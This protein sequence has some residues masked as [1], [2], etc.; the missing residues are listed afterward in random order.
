M[1]FR[2]HSLLLVLAVNS[3]KYSYFPNFYPLNLFISIFLH[4]LAGEIK[5][6]SIR[7]NNL[8]PK[9]NYTTELPGLTKN[10]INPEKQKNNEI[11]ITISI[12][13]LNRHAKRTNCKHTRRQFQS[14]FGRQPKY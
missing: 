2:L 14:G 6:T 4:N 1:Q 11:N 7:S 13:L 12:C 10:N 5:L 3:S 8:N 9:Y